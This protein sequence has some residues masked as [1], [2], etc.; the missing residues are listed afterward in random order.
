MRGS[1]SQYF[2]CRG[3]A[4]IVVMVSSSSAYRAH[5]CS[6]HPGREQSYLRL[7]S[8]TI[9]VSDH[10]RSLH[11]YRDQLGFSVAYAG[12]LPCGDHWLAVAPPDGTA[13]LTLIAP[14]PGS[15][16]YR[17]IGQPTQIAF[18]AEDIVGTFE[19][20]RSRGVRFQHLP[21]M[22]PS[23]AMSAD[24]EDMDGNSFTLLESGEMT[25]ELE[26]QRR[27]HIERAE[28]ERRAAQDLEMARQTQ[29]RLFP[30]IQPS[31]ATLEYGGFCIQTRH[32]G[33][34]YYDFLDLG[35]ARLGL[36]IGDVAGKGTAAALLMANL[37]AHLH[38]QSAMYWSRPFTP[39]VLG[40]PERFLGSVNRLFHEST[41]ENAY[42]TLFFA[43]YDDTARLL[44]YANCGHLPAVLLRSDGALER[45]DA[46]STVLGLF[47]EWDCAVGE[48][49]LSPGDT[50][51]LYTDGVTESFNNEGE[52]FGEQRLI[53]A[54]R[55]Y[56]G[57]S[58]SALLE[59]LV[60]EVR[61]FSPHQ[62]HDDITLV[63]ARC[64]ED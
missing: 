40:Q 22:Q 41:P 32:I 39:F 30:Q 57:C 55:R 28:L 14:R 46:T 58:S 42:A 9:F 44:R 23:G 50:L 31:L 51:A 15:E 63:V 16:E 29:A 49:R 36:A 10:A 45:L 4:I 18:L 33:G 37:Q 20:W 11:F 60:E 26:V 17:L 12:E 2:V 43:E 3:G 52:E 21:Q 35:R 27:E 19:E 34:D 61:Q 7:N 1:P 48:R 38:N 64:R 25:Q 53:E 6:F 13:V 47:K 59:S 54:L 56:S 5:R 24:F 62:Q 8:V